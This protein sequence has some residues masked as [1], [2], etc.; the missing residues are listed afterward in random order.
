[1]AYRGTK[2]KLYLIKQGPA[3]H[4]GPCFIGPHY[5]IMETNSYIIGGVKY[6]FDEKGYMK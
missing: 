2:L 4:A 1:M 6:G 3:A 5:G